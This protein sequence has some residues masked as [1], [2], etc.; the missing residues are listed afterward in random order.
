MGTCLIIANRTLAGEELLSE[1]ARRI[2]NGQVAFYVVV[3]ATPI[4][5]VLAWEEG[6]AL[7]AAAERLELI[8]KW[9]R[10]R[11]AQAD[12]EIGD[13][14]PVAATRDALRH[15]PADQIILSTL[16]IGRSRWIGQDVPSRLR[17]AVAVSIQVVTA[18]PQPRE[19]RVG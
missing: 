4:K 17:G 7:Q 16:P 2:D 10:A 19:A 15:R 9:L 5:H 3:P 18:S 13:R 14:D 1:V 6:E 12:G 8:L 11:G